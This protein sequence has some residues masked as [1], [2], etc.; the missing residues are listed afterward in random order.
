MATET[1]M[2]VQLEDAPHIRLVIFFMFGI[3]SVELAGGAAGGK[4]WTMEKG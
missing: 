1:Q 2:L 4:Q 3:D